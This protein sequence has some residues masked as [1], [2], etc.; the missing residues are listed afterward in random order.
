MLYS[1]GIITTLVKQSKFPMANLSLCFPFTVF[2]GENV[3][4]LVYILRKKP[5]AFLITLFQ[6]RVWCIWNH[7]PEM[8]K[9]AAINSV[10]KPKPQNI[11]IRFT[12]NDTKH[13][14]SFE[15]SRSFHSPE[16]LHFSLP[17]IIITWLFKVCLSC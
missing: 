13:C 6:R 11:F 4:L 5:T 14:V 3:K 8:I 17:T 7:I 10:C 16:L 2:T 15:F 9:I 1:T 12:Q